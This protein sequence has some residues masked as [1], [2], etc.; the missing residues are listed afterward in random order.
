MA[1]VTLKGNLVKL[2]GELP[3][4]DAI[5]PDFG[6]IRK[7]L[8][9]A[10]FYDYTGKTR[11]ILSFPSIDTDVCA[12]ETQVFNEAFNAKPDVMGLT[13]SHDLP[14][15]LNRFCMAQNIT[16]LEATSSFNSNFG[17]AYGVL[18]S[19]GALEGLLARA[20]FVVTPNNKLKYLELV[21][22]ITSEP[23]YGSLLSVL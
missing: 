9:R 10:N 18:I 21:P 23:N 4:I 6:F 3:K 12:K 8:S 17:Q 19:D 5:I 14:F 2:A 11:V 16:N 7:D 15:A 13:I 22:E 1:Q 20:V